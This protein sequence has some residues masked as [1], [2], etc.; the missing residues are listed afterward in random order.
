MKILYLFWHLPEISYLRYNPTLTHYFTKL[1]EEKNK[2]IRLYSQN[3][4]GLETVISKEKYK[5]LDLFVGDTVSIDDGIGQLAEGW[6]QELHA[7]VN[8]G[9]VNLM[10]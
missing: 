5:H 10:E 1:L 7:L 3:I 4:D 6:Q 2:S 8:K 9:G